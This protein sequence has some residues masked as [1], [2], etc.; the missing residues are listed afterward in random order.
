[1]HSSSHTS[2]GTRGG[3]GGGIAFRGNS[4]AG[5]YSI[6]HGSRTSVIVNSRDFHHPRHWMVYPY[7]YSYSTVYPYVY[8]P[9]YPLAYYDAYDYAVTAPAQ[10]VY[11]YD[12]S[13][14]TGEGDYPAEAGL[15]Q[16]MRQQQVGVYAQQYQP[17]NTYPNR[18]PGVDTSAPY[19]QRAPATYSSQPDQPATVLVY[20]D[21]RRA[22]IRNYGIVG[23]TLWVFSEQRAQKIALMD[24]DMDATRKANDERGIDFPAA[25]PK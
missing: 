16:Q 13:Y 22:E 8:Y 4:F 19:P 6:A 12:Y 23:Q 14:A 5:G 17:G 3:F 20:R 7:R 21:G 2:W 24:L 11:A 1:M 9:A 10:P 15:A 25:P 18:A